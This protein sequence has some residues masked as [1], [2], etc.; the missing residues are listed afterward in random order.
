MADTTHSSEDP[1]SL[2]SRSTFTT[3]YTK[4]KQLEARVGGWLMIVGGALFTAVLTTLGALSQK[5][6]ERTT[7]LD[8][9]QQ[10]YAG[11]FFVDEGLAFAVATY[12]VAMILLYQQLRHRSPV[13]SLIAVVTYCIAAVGFINAILALGRLLYPV[14]SLST[15][16]EGALL[17]AGQLFADVHFAAIALGVA[18]LMFGIALG[19]WLLITPSAAVGVLQIAGTYFGGTAPMWLLATSMLAWFVWSV[20][21]GLLMIRG[22]ANG[23]GLPTAADSHSD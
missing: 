3:N 20:V 18:I 6:P 15:S 1:H 10:N 19:R 22:R 5:L 16:E 7:V 12:S 2:K 17:S 21:V 23:G 13:T 9:A 8:W 14:N 4:R 11:L